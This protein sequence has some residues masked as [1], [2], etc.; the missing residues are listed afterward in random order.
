MD[1]NNLDE[2]L[3]MPESQGDVDYSNLSA[4]EPMGGQSSAFSGPTRFARQTPP[5]APPAMSV[6]GTTPPP[7]AVPNVQPKPQPM[8]EP[9][10]RSPFLS[11]IL[12]IFLSLILV[13]GILVFISWKGWISLGGIEKLWGGGK[14]SPT[15]TVVLS[16]E[17]T[18]SP[19]IVANTNDQT[20][21]ADLAK[22]KEA[23][24]KYFA[25]NG[26]FPQ[27]PDGVKTSD[28]TSALA[29]GLVPKYLDKLPDDPLAP[30][31]YYGYKSD[32]QSFELTA[33]LEDKTDSEGTSIGQ[34]FIYKLT[35]SVGT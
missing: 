14:A 4:P 34:F 16:T 10:P 24:T 27:A 33:V 1:D 30:Q 28:M 18:S 21:K 26:Q 32:G 13:A 22:I 2:P 11:L 7:A 15:P 6:P 25:D 12:M 19:S 23:L 9:G 29:Q 17:P 8:E 35:G 20:R 5:P 31:Y 3:K